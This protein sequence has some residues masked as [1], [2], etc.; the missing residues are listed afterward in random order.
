MSRHHWYGTW[1]TLVHPC[2]GCTNSQFVVYWDWSES[3]KG[4]KLVFSLCK[5]HC[6]QAGC[7]LQW[8]THKNAMR[9]ES[10]NCKMLCN[11]LVPV[12][13]WTFPEKPAK[14]YDEQ[15]FLLLEMKHYN[16]RMSVSN[17]NPQQPFWLDCS[18]KAIYK[19]CTV[20]SRGT[21]I[22][23][24]EKKHLYFWFIGIACF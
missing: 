9:P 17:P 1:D 14:Y 22:I 20:S 15:D 23:S 5:C 11:Q 4:S 10:S 2:A 18:S 16:V 13:D 6:R 12:T 24:T 7:D 3:N 21:Q 19:L 8:H